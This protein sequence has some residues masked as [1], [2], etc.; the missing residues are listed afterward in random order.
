MMASREMAAPGDGSRVA[1]KPDGNGFLSPV[2]L[3]R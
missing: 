3:S 1:P 2:W